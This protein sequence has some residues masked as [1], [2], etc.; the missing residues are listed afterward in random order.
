MFGFIKK[1]FLAG[2]TVLSYVNQLSTNQLSCI[3]MNN[4]ECKVRPE[5]I[6]VNSD[7]PVFYP[8]SIKTSKCSGSCNN[9]NDP[10]AKICVPDVV[11]DLNVKVFNLMSRTNETRHIKWHETCKCKCR[12]DASVCNNKQRWNDDKCR[13]ECKELID[14]GVCDRGYIWN[15]SNCECE[16]DKSCDV[17]EYLDYKN[18]KCRKKLGDKLVK[19]CNENI[20]EVKIVKMSIQINVVLAYCILF[21]FQCS[22][23]ST[24]ELLL[25]LFTTNT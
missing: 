25:I 6:N 1:A 10:Y 12:L 19:E 21:C 20:D 18:C 14:K 9:I 11:K 5:I 4:Q 16:C 15:P 13:C 7:E 3:S 8:F 2:L 23:Q 22:L 24:L 17:R